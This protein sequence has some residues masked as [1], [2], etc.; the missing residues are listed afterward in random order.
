MMNNSD[1]KRL[2]VIRN[3]GELGAYYITALSPRDLSLIPEESFD[4]PFLNPKL[5]I[6]SNSCGG[7]LFISSGSGHIYLC[8]PATRMVQMFPPREA[9]PNCSTVYIGGGVC[10]DSKSDDYKILRVCAQF[11]SNPYFMHYTTF[12]LYSLKEKSWRV[13]PN[14]TL[15]KYLDANVTCVRDKCYWFNRGFTGVECFDCSEETFS[16]LALPPKTRG[17]MYELVKFSDEDMLGFICYRKRGVSSKRRDSH[18]RYFGSAPGSYYELWVWKEEL[19]AWNMNFKVSLGGGVCSPQRTIYD[20]F[21]FLSGW[22]GT[23]Y[24]EFDGRQHR[25]LA[26]NWTK[27]ECKELGISNS[28]YVIPVHCYV[29]SN[30]ALPDGVPISESHTLCHIYLDED[31]HDDPDLREEDIVEVDQRYVEACK[32]EFL[33]YA[34]IDKGFRIVENIELEDEE[35]EVLNKVVTPDSRGGVTKNIGFSAQSSQVPHSPALEAEVAILTDELEQRK[36]KEEDMT[37]KMEEMQM[38]IAQLMKIN[39]P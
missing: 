15:P 19:R 16:H 6:E 29:E 12:D 33:D 34:D 28:R 31:G 5:R 37:R 39:R 7:L 25:L 11:Y 26:Y 21:L 20:Q 3:R 1:E 14:P 22:A 24:E 18:H 32:E 17:F 35:E 30:I 36:R 4:L 9:S 10:Y 2:L 27:K 13:I 23:R 8:N 38:Q